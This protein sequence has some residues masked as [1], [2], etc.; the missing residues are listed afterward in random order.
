MDLSDDLKKKLFDKALPLPEDII[1]EVIEALFHQCNIEQISLLAESQDNHDVILSN[2]FEQELFKEELGGFQLECLCL[3]LNIL[4][5][6]SY[7]N[8]KKVA[9]SVKDKV[10]RLTI[11]EYIDELGEEYYWD[12][13]ILQEIKSKAELAVQLI[14]SIEEEIEQEGDFEEINGIQFKHNELIEDN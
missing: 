14:K 8:K 11:D 4:R 3:S 1:K 2:Q 9:L 13:N 10:I 6:G 7:S 12:D 5:L